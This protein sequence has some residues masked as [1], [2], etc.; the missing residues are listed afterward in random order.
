MKISKYLTIFVVGVGVI[1]CSKSIPSE[2]D[3]KKPILSLIG[4][5]QYLSLEKFQKTNGMQKG[6][7]NY[8]V[9]IE[10]EIHVKPIPEIKKIIDEK[11][12]NLSSID[13]RL[14]N[15]RD[16]LAVAVKE[17]NSLVE[18]HEVTGEKWQNAMENHEKLIKL[19]ES[20]EKEKKDFL[21]R[22]INIEAKYLEKCPSINPVLFANLYG[23]DDFSKYTTEFT[24][25][26]GGNMAM[27][28]TENG[29]I[30]AN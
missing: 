10:Y 3:A 20:V 9:A 7:N 11:L 2:E 30:P 6:D 29:W 15:A 28:R 23:G 17:M 4:G 14:K 26:F 5:C 12:V 24:K 27:I 13:E 8:I 22:V 25:Q 21:G 1:G 18:K 19:N 16:Q